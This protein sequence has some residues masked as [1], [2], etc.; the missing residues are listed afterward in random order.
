MF[1]VTDTIGTSVSLAI[2]TTLMFVLPSNVV[3]MLRRITREGFFKKNIVAV[4]FYASPVKNLI[5]IVISTAQT[6]LGL[7]S[8]TFLKINKLP[9][10]SENNQ[11]WHCL[12]IV[13]IQSDEL[14]FNFTLCS[15]P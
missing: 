2:H 11:G 12:K 5:Y 14:N 7:R 15:K 1:H 6:D 8:R 9:A 10:F 13:F 3:M 4:S